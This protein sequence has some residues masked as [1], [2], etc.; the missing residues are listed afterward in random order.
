MRITT[1]TAPESEPVTLTEVKKHLRLATTDAEA[2][3]YTSE[4]DLLNRLITVA[5]TQAEQE[6]GRAFITQTKTYYLDAWPDE[7]FIKIPY[8]TL[9][10]ATVTYRLEDDDDYDETLSTVDTDTVSEPG[11][12]VLQPNESWPSDALYTDRPIKIVFDCGYGDAAAN[13]P[14]NI[15][16]AI[17]LKISDLYENRGEVVMGVSVSKIADAVDSLLRQYRIFTEFD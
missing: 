7:T 3:A 9:Q 10:S 1:T 14:E 16:S 4:D 5:R 12:L 17:L 13:V 15:K 6:T 2:A 8:P 11:R